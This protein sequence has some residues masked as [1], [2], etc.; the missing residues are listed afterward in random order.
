MLTYFTTFSLFIGIIAATILIAYLTDR[1]FK[2]LIKRSARDLSNDPTNYQFIKHLVVAM[3]YIIGIALAIYSIPSLRTIASSMLAGAGI[4][5]VAVSFASQHALSNIVSGVFMVIFK[6]FRVGDRLSIRTFNG[7]VEDITLRHTVIRDFENKRVLIPNSLISNEILVNPDFVDDKI[8]KWL[9][10]SISYESS[11][12][13][14]KRIIAEAVM[15][16]PLNLDPRTEEQ[17]ANGTPQVIVRVVS[18]GESS[19]NIRAWAWAQNMSNGF[20]MSC[21]LLET[22][23]KQFDKEGIEIPYPHRTVTIKHQNTS[24]LSF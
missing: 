8:C 6:P 21:D 4:I 5:A 12:D 22:I 17:L 16:H 24:N 2:R 10:F 3:V 1:F 14:A 18:F 19:V 13:V 9:D 23:K 11:I 20:I 7:I 15:D